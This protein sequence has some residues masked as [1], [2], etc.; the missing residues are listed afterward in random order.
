[1]LNL[2]GSDERDVKHPHNTKECKD[3]RPVEFVHKQDEK[4]QGAI[5]KLNYGVS[6]G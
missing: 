6:V 1:M 3:E 4:M 2:S 5:H